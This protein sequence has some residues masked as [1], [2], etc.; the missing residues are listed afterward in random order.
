MISV[1]MSLQVLCE[2]VFPIEVYSSRT[3]ESDF[4]LMEKLSFRFE[5]LTFSVI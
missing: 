1:Q 3:L 5:F 2:T 4:E